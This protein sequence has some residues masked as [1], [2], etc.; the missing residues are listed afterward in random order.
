MDWITDNIAIGNYL[1]ARDK[2]LITRENIQSIISLDGECEVFTPEPCFFKRKIFNLIDGP[3]ND[4]RTFTRAVDTL[5]TFVESHPPVLV[6]CHAGRSRSPIVVAG[7]LIVKEKME[8]EDA[9][10][11]VGTK[12]EFNISSG[13]EELLYYL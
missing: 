11:F 8:P 6:H 9:L 2:I 12:R 7:Y 3:G 13:L 10:A 4:M 5:I 1:D